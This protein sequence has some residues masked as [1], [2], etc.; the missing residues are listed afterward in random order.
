M[1]RALYAAASGMAAQQKNL[2]TI[3]DN[4]AN[5]DG[6]LTVYRLWTNEKPKEDEGKKE[7]GPEKKAEPLI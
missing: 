2:E 6:S 4:L 3:A 1:N 5:A 7:A